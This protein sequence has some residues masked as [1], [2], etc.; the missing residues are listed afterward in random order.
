MCTFALVEWTE[1]SDK[2][3]RSIL[4][5][6]CVRDFNELN[7]LNGDE[8]TPE[9]F[10]V[11]WRH[12]RKAANRQWPVYQARIIKVAKWEKSLKRIL[13]EMETNDEADTSKRVTKPNL[14]YVDI[15]EEEKG[16]AKKRAHLDE[17]ERP[18]S[19]K[20]E[21]IASLAG[22]CAATSVE[23]Q[24]T[25][26]AA[27]PQKKQPGDDDGD[28]GNNNKIHGERTEAP[29][30][31]EAP[32]TIEIVKGLGVFCK[33]DAW[34]ASIHT[35]SGTAMV[36]T[37]LLGTF[38]LETLLQSNL[39]GGKPKR[40]DGEQLEA[41]DPGKKAAIIAINGRIRISIRATQ[42]PEF[43]PGEDAQLHTEARVPAGQQ[44]MTP[45]VRTGYAA[46]RLMTPV[47]RTGY[48]AHRL[49]KPVVRTGYSAHRPMKRSFAHD[50]PV[51]C[52]RIE[53]ASDLFSL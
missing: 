34:K 2:G 53:I 6:D 52:R 19:K 47:V 29:E 4:P 11:E 24:N 1:G 38:P 44:Q 9:E 20:K 46:H 18:I 8:E 49:M 51:A 26:A 27:E 31:T 41:L 16:P 23:P 10:L 37:L 3:L 40:G 42:K 25:V 12:G 28:G 43:A 5:I 45:V 15:D 7:Y 32:E 39:N 17:E 13:C 36:Q 21:D 22:R 30:K 14:R 48:A 50:T 35:T 33:R